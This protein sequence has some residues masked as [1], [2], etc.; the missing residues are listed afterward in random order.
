M[1]GK[2]AGFAPLR[3]FPTHRTAMLKLG[4]TD[5]NLTASGDWGNTFPHYPLFKVV[6]KS[7]PDEQVSGE[8]GR[9]RSSSGS[10]TRRNGGTTCLSRTSAFAQLHS[11][12]RQ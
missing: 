1:T 3:I 5:T 6:P 8:I 4:I 11:S 12:S 2:S 7:G 10:A 9:R